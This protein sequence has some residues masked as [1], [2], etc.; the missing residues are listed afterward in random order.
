MI[1]IIINNNVC[2]CVR[3]WCACACHSAIIE[4]RKHG[5]WGSKADCQACVA[6]APRTWAHSVRVCTMLSLSDCCSP[7]C[8]HPHNWFN[9]YLYQHDDSVFFF[10]RKL[11]RLPSKNKSNSS[12]SQMTAFFSF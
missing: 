2:V 6:S 10:L 1:I 9:I 4:L 5:F 12:S 8:P 11:G 3:V 7:V